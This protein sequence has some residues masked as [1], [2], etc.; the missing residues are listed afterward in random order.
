M[1]SNEFASKLADELRQ[2]LRSV[3]FVLVLFQLRW[4]REISAGECGERNTRRNGM[5][6]DAKTGRSPLRSVQKEVI[7]GYVCAY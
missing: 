7:G 6:V 4:L 1:V 2:A 5:L 3:A